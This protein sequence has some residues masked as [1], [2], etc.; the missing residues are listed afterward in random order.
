MNDLAGPY[1]GLKIAQARARIIEDL[2][3]QG[4]ALESAQTTHTIGVHERCGTPIEYLVSGQWF[5]G[6][7]ALREQLLEAGRRVRWHPEYMRARYESWVMGLSWDW[8]ISRQRYY[9]VPFPLWY[10]EGCGVVVLASPDRLPID[11]TTSQ[12]D[13]PC[14]ICGGTTFRPETDVMDTWATSSR[15]PAICASLAAE[16]GLDEETFL[17]Q[18]MSLR[19]NAHDIIR[20][21]DFYTIVQSLLHYG[22][23][24]WSDLM[25]AG[26]AQ[27]LSGKKLSKSKLKAADD[28]T[29]TIEQYSA[30]AVRYWTAG[31]RTGGDTAVSDEAFR[32]GNRLITKLWN[33][34]RFALLHEGAAS[35]AHDQEAARAQAPASTDR[36]RGSSAMR[37][38]SQAV[39]QSEALPAADRWLLARLGQTVARATSAMED[40]E[41]ATARAAIERFFWSDFCDTYLELVKYRL[42]GRGLPDGTIATP[43]ERAAAIY[44]L[45]MALR[46][47]LKLLAPFLP[48]VTEEI[49]LQGGF[50]A[51]Q[52]LASIHIA[53]W[54]DAATFPADQAALEAGEIMLDVVEAARRWKAE[55]NLSVGAPIDALAIT[56]PATQLGL[57]QEMR[58]D[59]ACITRAAAVTVQAG[60][61]VATRIEAGLKGLSS[62]V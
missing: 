4:P 54:P 16:M 26:H 39:Q 41:P 55:R 23:I 49:Y 2:Q 15:T 1:A 17:A 47:V 44:T 31:V 21:W 48:H 30:D 7:L 8:N 6:V 43:D 3:A 19:P 62:G 35:I 12:P 45:R 61:S 34:A 20:T 32:Q 10:C 37:P 13:A 38:Q 29:A 22:D 24:P 59:L 51:E 57:L 50:A 46:T 53:R 33:A 40:Y 42:S 11:P 52:D 56:C 28:P 58:L 5:I 18:P 25:I 60:P 36:S 27:D 9:G 14:P